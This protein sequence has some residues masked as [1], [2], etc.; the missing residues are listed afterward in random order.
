[1]NLKKHN[2]IVS[3]RAERDLLRV[4]ARVQR[5][6]LAWIDVVKA[7]GLESVRRIFGYH[8]EPLKGRRFGQRS[9]RLNKAYRAIYE[10]EEQGSV[11]IIEIKE[12]TKHDY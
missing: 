2:I 5:K 9:I 12:V 3:E 6:L 1:M 4:P 8:D 11:R 10:I 7:E